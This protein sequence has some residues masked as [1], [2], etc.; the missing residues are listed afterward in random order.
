MKKMPMHTKK[1]DKMMKERPMPK[2]M[3]DGHEK[4]PMKKVK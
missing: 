4:T 2:P 1:M 3:K